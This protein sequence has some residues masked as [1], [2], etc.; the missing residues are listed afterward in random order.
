MFVIAVVLATAVPASAATIT[1]TVVKRVQGSHKFVIASAA[2]R[3]VAVTSS[4]SPR[5]GQTVQLVTRRLRSGAA[6]VRAMRVVGRRSTVRVRG[7][8]TGADRARRVFTISG[9]G[10]AIQLRQSARGARAASAQAIPAVGTKVVVR[11]DIQGDD[12]LI[13]DQIDAQGGARATSPTPTTTPG[14]TPST[15]PAPPA[16]GTPS[17]APTPVVV[18]TSVDFDGTIGAI[19]GQART[20]TVNGTAPGS[21][22]NKVV[23]PV[24]FDMSQFHI[25][26]YIH[27]Q[28]TR[29]A[30]GTLAFDRIV[31]TQYQDIATTIVAIDGSA[32][33]LTT[34][35]CD[36]MSCG[37]TMSVLV[38]A[39]IDMSQFHVGQQ[40]ALHVIKRLDG[41]LVLACTQS[42]GFR[43]NRDQNDD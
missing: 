25:G 33:T 38:P 36:M 27:M 5:V 7:V 11:A 22:P 3:L 23:I 37:P 4:R 10:A 30:D 35:S 43:G 32:R 29:Q 16:G 28:A 8:V 6:S 26:D 18:P 14:S 9:S 17:P 20:V 15:T 2:G 40:V 42:H 19:D 1:G 24:P 12:N 13:A 21:A 31:P 39:S 41:T 34:R